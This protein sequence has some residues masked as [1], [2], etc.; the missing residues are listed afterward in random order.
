MRERR[1]RQKKTTRTK[2]MARRTRTTRLAR[3]AGHSAKLLI[4]TKITPR[5]MIRTWVVTRMARKIREMGE[6]RTRQKMATKTKRMARRTRTTRLA[7]WAGHSAKLLIMTKITPRKMIRTWMV[8][9]M[10]RK[11]REMRERRTRQKKTTKTKRMARRTRTI[12]L[13]R[14]AGHSAKL[15]IMTKII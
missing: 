5:K 12:S 2:R 15:M 10:A 1:T 4:M 6:R 7:R 3:W 9:R 8:T 13:A 14:W 11:I